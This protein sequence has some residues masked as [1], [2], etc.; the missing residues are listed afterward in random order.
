MGSAYME[1]VLDI[2]LPTV[3]LANNGSEETKGTE[4]QLAAFGLLKESGLNFVGNIEARE[5]PTGAAD[6]VVCDGFTG[7]I[8]LKL[9]E[10]MAKMFSG[11]IKEMFYKSF[12]TK[13]AGVMM[14]DGLAD[15]KKR[16]D[17][18]EYGG[19]PMLGIKKPVI[20]AHGSSDEKAIK[21][22]IR[23]AKL[24]AE[25]DL[26]GVIENWV[27]QHKAEEQADD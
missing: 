24:C 10:G 26:S 13:M 4:L 19:A 9:V 27:A 22:A 3:A 23:Q 8:I 6:V 20:K 14:K 21:N 16:F 5:I 7:N 15:F 18:T 11:M 12:K 25:N 17:Y 2:P 1:K